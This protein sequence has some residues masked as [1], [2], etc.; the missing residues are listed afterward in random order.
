MKTE[1]K[2]SHTPVSTW[3]RAENGSEIVE[4]VNPG[5]EI[6]GTAVYAQD[7][8]LWAAAPELLEGLIVLADKMMPLDWRVLR[9]DQVPTWFVSIRAAIAAAE[10][11]EDR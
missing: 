10:G 7:A 4:I 1:K 5:G 2:P 6:I 8:E 3:R 11:R 9:D